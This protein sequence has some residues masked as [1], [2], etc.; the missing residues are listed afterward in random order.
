[1]SGRI[2]ACDLAP[3]L[4]YPAV[5]SGTLIIESSTTLTGEVGKVTRYWVDKLNL[6]NNDI[7][8]IDTT[9]GPVELRIKGDPDDWWSNIDFT[10]FAL[11]DHAKIVNVRTDGKPPRLGDLRIIVN[12]HYPL[13]MT[14]QTCIQNAFLWTPVDE[15]WLMTSG[16]GCAGGRGTNFE[17]V[18][19]A[20]AILSSK[21]APTN[22][23]VAYL[24][25]LNLPYDTT[26]TPGATSGIFVPDDLSSLNDLFPRLN[27]PIRYRI[28][29]ILGWRQ[30]RM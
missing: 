26:I 3:S 23:N 7:L 15:M 17:G 12:G 24:G 2:T 30:V 6:D 16:P 21:N 25:N 11:A 18:V 22:R 8:T 27:W 13:S 14:G 4:A 5:P 10:V 29:D 19:W 20:E 28:R 9:A 1:V